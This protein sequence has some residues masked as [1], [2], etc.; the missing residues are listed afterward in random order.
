MGD[1]DKGGVPISRADTDAISHYVLRTVDR[2]EPKSLR[3]CRAFLL[4]EGHIL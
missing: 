4:S 2:K 3:C 1:P